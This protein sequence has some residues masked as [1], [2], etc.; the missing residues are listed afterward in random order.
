MGDPTP[1]PGLVAA[2]RYLWNLP[3]D[4]LGLGNAVSWSCAPSKELREKQK[5]ASA[6]AWRSNSLRIPARMERG[7]GDLR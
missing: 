3:M 2:D 7:K 6:L 5:K 1:S 4:S